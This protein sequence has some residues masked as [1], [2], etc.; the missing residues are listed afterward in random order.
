M[1][2]FIRLQKMTKVMLD[3]FFNKFD[4]YLISRNKRFLIPHRKMSLKK[5]MLSD[6]YSSLSET[7]MRQTVTALS[8]KGSLYTNRL[9]QE[10]K[11]P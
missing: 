5:A 4:R 10:T 6:S 9:L 7:E 1:R 8:L 11:H 2:R 3:L